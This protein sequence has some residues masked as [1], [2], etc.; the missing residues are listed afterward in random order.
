MGLSIVVVIVIFCCVHFC[1]CFDLF[2][3]NHRVKSIGRERQRERKLANVDGLLNSTERTHKST[4]KSIT[5][6]YQVGQCYC[7]VV[8]RTNSM[9]G[10]SIAMVNLIIHHKSNVDLIH[11]FQVV[12]LAE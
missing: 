6:D 8:Y 11:H 12:S 3:H 1:C 4:H 9:Y 5:Y 10:R 7:R 2:L